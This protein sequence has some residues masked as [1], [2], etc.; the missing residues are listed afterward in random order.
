MQEKVT[1]VKF[2]MI[3]TEMLT[4]TIVLYRAKAHE[5]MN[6]CDSKGRTM[7]CRMQVHL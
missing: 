7:T 5:M 2:E 1:K 6:D 3:H 4:Q